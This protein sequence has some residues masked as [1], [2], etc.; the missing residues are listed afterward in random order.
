MIKFEEGTTFWEVTKGDEVL[1][2]LEKCDSFWQATTRGLE[3]HGLLISENMEIQYKLDE[4]NYGVVPIVEFIKEREERYQVFYT[5]INKHGG[6]LSRW[7]G[8]RRWFFNGKSSVVHH[9]EESLQS[10]IDKLK[11]LNND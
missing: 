4:L 9:S 7:P 11:E 1:C 8:N 5:Q 2:Y 3:M 6:F 10:I